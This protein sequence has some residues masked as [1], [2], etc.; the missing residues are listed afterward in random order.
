MQRPIALTMAA[1]AVAALVAGPAP[2]Q[3]EGP[4]APPPRGTKADPPATQERI[5]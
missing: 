5:S 2:A 3:E 4:P 1:L